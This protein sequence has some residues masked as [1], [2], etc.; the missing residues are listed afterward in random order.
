VAFTASI[1]DR[2]WSARVWKWLRV[3]L[4]VTWYRPLCECPADSYAAACL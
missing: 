4:D 3:G 1:I 2:G